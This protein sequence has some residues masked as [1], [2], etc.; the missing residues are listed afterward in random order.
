MGGRA[1]PPGRWPSSLGTDADIVMAES[2]NALPEPDRSEVER[3]LEL[4]ALDL[5]GNP[6]LDAW[7]GWNLSRATIAG[8][9]GVE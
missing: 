3:S 7:L 2:L 4:T 8:L 1:A 6:Y 9:L 5:E